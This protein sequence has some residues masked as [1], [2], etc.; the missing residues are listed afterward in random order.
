MP[1]DPKA[2]SALATAV[3]AVE[4][5]SIP[6]RPPAPVPVLASFALFAAT[7]CQW[8][9]GRASGRAPGR[10]ARPG[11]RSAAA[12]GCCGGRTAAREKTRDVVR[13]PLLRSHR[14]GPNEPRDYAEHRG[15]SHT[16]TGRVGTA[17]CWKA[18]PL[19]RLTLRKAQG[20]SE[21]SVACAAMPHEPALVAGVERDW[22]HAW[23]GLRAGRSAAGT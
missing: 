23:K 22:P 2:C 1:T 20:G 4:A 10:Q 6:A 5:S 13:P 12:H 8:H 9:T 16:R 7:E 21:R 17:L 11:G 18:R 3:E 15:S 19:Q 14:P